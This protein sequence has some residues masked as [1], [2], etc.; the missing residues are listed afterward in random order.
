MVSR[1]FRFRDTPRVSETPCKTVAMT[2]MSR[3]QQPCCR[4][5]SRLQHGILA[6]GHICRERLDSSLNSPATHCQ[7]N[8]RPAVNPEL[9]D[10]VLQMCNSINCQLTINVPSRLK[11]ARTS[12][13]DAFVAA[14][15]EIA[16][17]GCVRTGVSLKKSRTGVKLCLRGTPGS[18]GPLRCTVLRTCLLPMPPL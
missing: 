3:V 12:D 15:D 5:E 1:C 11:R 8:K 6:L 7:C 9:R 16:E 10:I 13:R 4:R 2:F 17:V 18:S 14:V